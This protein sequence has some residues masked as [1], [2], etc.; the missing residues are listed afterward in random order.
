MFVDFKAV[1]LE[2]L[3]YETDTDFQVFSSLTLLHSFIRQGKLDS[4]S[5]MTWV[6]LS[7]TSQSVPSV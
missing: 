6:F 1:E 5:L 2:S 7:L 3:D 4:K